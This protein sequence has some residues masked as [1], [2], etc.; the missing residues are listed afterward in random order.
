MGSFEKVGPSRRSKTFLLYKW[1]GE[2]FF[3]GLS[4]VYMGV[5]EWNN[6]SSLFLFVIYIIIHN[7]SSRF[8][9]K[10][11]KLF[12]EMQLWTIAFL[13]I[14]I[15]ILDFTKLKKLSYTYSRENLKTSL[16]YS[17]YRLQTVV[18]H[19]RIVGPS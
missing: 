3:N 5:V 7:V 6:Q 11:I 13:A 12:R 1:V 8:I 10:C 2:V 16:D 4:P 14:F 15:Y 18:P 17:W 19:F 9:M